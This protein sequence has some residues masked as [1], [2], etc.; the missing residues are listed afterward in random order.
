M[1]HQTLI[2]VKASMKSDAFGVRG[3]QFDTWPLVGRG[4][5]ATERNGGPAQCLL[6][7]NY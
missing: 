2:F 7:L 6:A 4:G 5:G 1:I 3:G